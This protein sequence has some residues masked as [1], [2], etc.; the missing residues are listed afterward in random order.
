MLLEAALT[1]VSKFQ[2]LAFVTQAATSSLATS[3]A[4][5]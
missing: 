1:A 3:C 2:Q 4:F 5:L